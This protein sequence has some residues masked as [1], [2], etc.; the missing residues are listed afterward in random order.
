M[1]F[2]CHL[3]DFRLHNCTSCLSGFL[4]LFF[5]FLLE[6]TF[7]L[8]SGLTTLSN[9]VRASGCSRNTSFE[10]VQ[11]SLSCRRSFRLQYQDSLVPEYIFF[12]RNRFTRASFEDVTTFVFEDSQCFEAIFLTPRIDIWS[13]E[14][15]DVFV[16]KSSWVLNWSSLGTDMFHSSSR[17]IYQRLSQQTR[18]FQ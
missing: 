11:T 18:K 8:H 14:V 10:P 1:I 5:K 3:S 16:M 15:H 9:F 17:E 7:S 12:V 2:P 13:F 6:A 4:H